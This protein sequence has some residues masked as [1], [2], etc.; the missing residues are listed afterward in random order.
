MLHILLMGLILI[1]SGIFNLYVASKYKKDMFSFPNEET[2]SKMYYRYL[3]AGIM[4]IILGV[5]FIFS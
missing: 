5:S 2:I 4:L 1:L 3:V